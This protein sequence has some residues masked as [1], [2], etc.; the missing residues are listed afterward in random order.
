MNPAVAIFVK[1]PGYSDIKTRL[2][3]RL[4]QRFAEN[5]H[6]RAA[7]AVAA[8]VQASGLSGYWAVAEAG[9]VA[10]AAWAGL[11]NLDQG[12]GE[13]GERM[14][15]IHS[16]LVRRHG[17]GILV[18]ADLPQLTPGQLNRAAAWLRSDDPRR[19][20]G[21]ATDGGFWLFGANRSFDLERWQ[22][23]GYSRGDTARRFVQTLAPDAPWEILETRTDL[24]RAEDLPAL[25]AEL[26]ALT[27]PLPVQQALTE[28]LEDCLDQAA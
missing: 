8:S 26:K 14:A 5:W 21:P 7:A 18:G 15:R 24:D 20:L 4:G 3:A 27:S 11:A 17:A 25:L 23:V 12:E 16:E 28:W 6:R 13:L 2:A 10:D 19:V 9:A 22:A 1:T